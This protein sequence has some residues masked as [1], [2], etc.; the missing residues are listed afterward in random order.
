MAD[1]KKI[2]KKTGRHGSDK[3]PHRTDVYYTDEEWQKLND[4]AAAAGVDS[5]HLATFVRELALKGKVKAIL[6]A[7]DRRDINKLNNIGTNLWEVRKKLIDLNIDDE[8]AK[9]LAKFK[10]EFAEILKYFKDKKDK[11]ARRKRDV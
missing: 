3:R 8:L 11:K 6:S 5:R 1:E 9:D 10:T 2:E 7:E 4:M